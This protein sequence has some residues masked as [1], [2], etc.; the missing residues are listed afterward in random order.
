MAFKSTQTQLLEGFWSLNEDL[1]ICMLHIDCG[2]DG[3]VGSIAAKHI[4]RHKL[5]RGTGPST[6][7]TIMALAI[8][9][10]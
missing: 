10:K 1:H 7:V 8:I 2:S 3:M 9:M 4:A 6:T 5:Y